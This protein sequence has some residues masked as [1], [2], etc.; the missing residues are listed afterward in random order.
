MLRLNQYKNKILNIFYDK[1]ICPYLA[2]KTFVKLFFKMLFKIIWQFLLH[3][4]DFVLK[5][6]R[7]ILLALLNAF[8]S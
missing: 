2:Y 6:I 4:N 1:S 7:N 8:F 3:F 5:E